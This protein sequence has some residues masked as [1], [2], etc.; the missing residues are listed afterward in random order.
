L[1]RGAELGFG[2]AVHAIQRRFVYT[3][4]FADDFGCHAGLP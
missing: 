3:D 1:L 2:Y 4:V